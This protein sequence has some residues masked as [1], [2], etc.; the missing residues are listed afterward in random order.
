MKNAIKF[1]AIAA[2][3][4][5]ITLLAGC[6]G[7]NAAT[8]YKTTTS[9]NWQIRG[10]SADELSESS[11]LMTKRETAIYSVT[12]NAG[13][14]TNYSVEY[15]EGG[16]YTTV[17]Y[18]TTYDWNSQDI[19]EALRIENQ[20]DCVYVYETTLQLEGAYVMDGNRAPFTTAV[21]TISY[22]RSAANNLLPVYSMQ[23]I[24]TASPGSINPAN[25]DSAYVEMDRVYETYYSRDGGTAIV[26]AE[27]RGDD[28]IDNADVTTGTGSE[29]SLFDASSLGIA[30]RSM[31][32]SGTPAFDVFVPTN[33]AG[34][35][36]QAVWGASSAIARDNES[37]SSIISALDSAVDAGYIL[38][39][40]NDEGVREY[41]FTPAVVSLVSAM[42]GPSTT[43]YYLTVTNT[44]LNAGRAALAR[45]EEQLPFS[46]GTLVYNLTSLTLN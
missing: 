22:F 16:T 25:L 27:A 44:D 26:H 29:Y 28:S 17:L 32:Q 46:L 5:S 42:T 1:I 7:C 11:T 9:P 36:Y 21:H 6:S 37:Y 23:D 13:A 19:P 33:G 8:N 31:T 24:K 30:L 14:N 45:V 38:T 3:A 18:A 40:A 43:Y 10:G 2:C 15:A 12:H 35:R 39:G 34:A 4:A 41:A 20:T